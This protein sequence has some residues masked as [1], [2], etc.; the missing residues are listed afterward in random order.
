MKKATT[1][2]TIALL[3]STLFFACKKDDNNSDDRPDYKNV[4]LGKWLWY[5]TITTGNQA[6][7]LNTF[8]NQ[9]MFKEFLA[10]GKVITTSNG[11][12][13]TTEN[14]F[15]TGSK[16]AQTFNNGHDTGYS[17]ITTFNAG[18]FAIYDK[19]I[20]TNVNP[21]AVVEYWNYFVK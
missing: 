20:Y 8:Y 2:F 1:I 18:A 16:L 6:S 13:T 10:N 15:I 7:P 19:I 5:K 17:D 3:S 12:P 14:Y 9:G 11:S 4:I 21:N